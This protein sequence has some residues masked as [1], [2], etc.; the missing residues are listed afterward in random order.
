VFETWMQDARYA[1][2]LL[3]RGP[4]FTLTAALSLAIGIGA[5]T[6]IFSVASATLLRPLPGLT[7]AGQLIDIGRTRGGRG[8]DT[9]SYPTY[10]DVRE[11]ATTLSGVFAIRLEPQPMSL[12]GPDAAESVYG[13]AVSGN[14]FAVLGTTPR[15][16]RLF[17]DSDDRRDG[18]AIVISHE[19]WQRRFGGDATIVGREIT[20]NGAPRVVIGVAP[21]GFQ[22]TTLLRSDLW[23]PLTARAGGPGGADLLTERRAVWLFMGGRLEPGVTIQQADA[24]LRAI[25]EA[26]AREYPDALRDRGLTAAASAVIPGRINMVS[27]FLAVLMGIVSLVLLI[28]CVNVAGMLLARATARRREIAVRLAIGAGRARLV[29]QLLTET[30]VLFGAGCAIGLVLSGWLTSLLLAVLPTLPL[31]LGVEI[32]TDWRVVVFALGLSLAAAVL[33]G[34]AP[35]LQASRPDLVPSL[36]AGGHSSG[37]SRLRLRN[38]FVVGQITLSLLLVLA[39]GLLLRALGRAV[40]IDPGF[41][42]ANVEVVSTDFALAGLTDEQGRLFANELV[43]R[44][45]ALPSVRSAAL[46]VD[47]P[48]DGGRM[49]FG[50]VRLPGSTEATPGG[51]APTDWNVVTPT[52]FGTLGVTLLRGRDFTDADAGGTPRVGIVNQALGRRLF[53][54]ADPIGRQVEVVTPMSRSAE[55]ITIVGVAADARFVS[56]NETATPYFYVPLAQQYRSRVSLLVKTTGSTSIPQVRALVR[57]MNPNL[58]VTN[59]MALEQVTALGLVPQRIAAAVA[60]TLGVVGLLLAAIGI[61]GVASYTVSRRTREIGIRLALGADRGSVLRLILRQGL[62]LTA[63]GVTIGLACGAAASQLLR[64]LLF[65]VSVLDPLTF[66]GAPLLFVVIALAATYLPGRRATRMDPMVALRAE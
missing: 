23:F 5:N 57:Q 64:S 54:D 42:Q 46:T 45:R 37:T 11:R 1:L 28:A 38:A 56:L 3:R 31:P 30:V 34:L 55:R 36:K 6:T 22:G 47:L 12:A 66:A 14:Y 51:T 53:G 35:A 63:I 49:S 27:G 9:V 24:E 15:L 7:D 59:A 13:T 21:A 60:G 10:Q 29:R 43:E 61:Y 52:F 65:G 32:T 19:L 16:G 33:S 2:R 4:A 25:G 62:I 20:V 40:A 26:L 41:D 44:T 50:N 58:P 8:F 18:P 48:L 39:A 17:T